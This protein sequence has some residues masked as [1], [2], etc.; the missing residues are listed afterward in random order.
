MGL[1]EIRDYVKGSG[2][3]PF[4]KWLK[5][6]KDKKSVDII[7][8]R[9]DRMAV[10]SF[11][12]ARGVGGG[13]FELRIHFGPGYRIYYGLHANTII[14]LLC[15]GDKSTQTRDIEVAKI[16]WSDYWRRTR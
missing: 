2:I 10:G 12:D 6:L 5:K 15:G 11:G 3:V 9:I 13:V 16:F 7:S 4:R 1:Y 14:V 8:S